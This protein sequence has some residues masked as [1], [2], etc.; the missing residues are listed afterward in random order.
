MTSSGSVVVS[1]GLGVGAGEAPR[2]TCSGVSAELVG[3]V[4]LFDSNASKPR[5]FCVSSCK[6]W[7]FFALTICDLNHVLASS[8]STSS[9]LPWLSSMCLPRRQAESGEGDRSRSGWRTYLFSC[10]SVICADQLDARTAE[11][12]LSSQ[13]YHLL[14]TD[15]Q[16][17]LELAAAAAAAAA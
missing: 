17:I 3:G 5:S 16:T 4:S 9:K 11:P 8:C 7:N 12:C 1:A 13:T 6:G 2:L 14:V 15:R 10:R